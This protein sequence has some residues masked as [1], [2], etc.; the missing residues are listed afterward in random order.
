MT[1]DPPSDGLRFITTPNIGAACVWTQIC[2]C[3]YG[4]TSIEK[5]LFKT[6]QNLLQYLQHSTSKL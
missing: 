3:L 6:C 4:S 5:G 1:L 2:A